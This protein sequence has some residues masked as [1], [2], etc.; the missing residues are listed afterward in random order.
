MRRQ[1]IVGLL[2][3]LACLVYV[4][5]EVDFPRLWQLIKDINPL[6]PLAVNALYALVFW[7]RSLR[8]RW[9]LAPVKAC[10]LG[11]LYSATIIGFMGN[12][13]LPARLGE[14][15]RAYALS[16]LE[17]TPV[18]SVLGSLVVERLLDG[19]TILALLFL[20]L[21]FVDPRAQAG[22]F[23][24][25][26]LRAAGLGLF[27]LYLVV[28]AVVL[29]LVFRPEA[30]E[31]LLRGLTHRVWPSLAP[32]VGR[33]A[34]NFSQGLLALRRGGHLG[35]LVGYSLLVWSGML[36]MGWVFLPAV[37]LPSSPL[38]AAMALVGGAMAAAVPAG[39]GFVGTYQLAATWSL[40]LVGVDR[41]KALAFSLIYWAVQYFPLVVA[42]LIE[43]W[44]RG[45]NLESL[46]QKGRE[47]AQEEEGAAS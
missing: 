40:M 6:Y 34:H 7:F 25:E 28:L 37:G 18:S 24:A 21:L 38:L 9:L 19:L 32:K 1:A 2:L 43:M 35:R 3:S 30:T 46:G 4:L 8:W 33:T 5:W 22:A 29:G 47:L 11:R 41:E 42:G 15:V 36:G 17:T 12:N 13:V 26:H 20:T 10:G 23:S 14:F 31:R 44:R 16:R 39:P 27:L 45:M